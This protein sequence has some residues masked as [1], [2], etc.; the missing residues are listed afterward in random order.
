[1]TLEGTFDPVE[2]SAEPLVVHRSGTGPPVV[3]VHGGMPAPMTW[4]AQQELTADWSL[5]VPNRRGFPPS[6]TAPWQDFLADTDDLADLLEQIPGGAHLAG[7]SYGGLGAVL[8][9][10]RLPHL[11][12]SLT[13]IE[14]PLWIAAEDDDAVRELAELSDRFA[15]SVDD[16]EAEAEFFAVAGVDP[17]MFAELDEDVRQALELGRKLRSP[18]EAKPRFETITEAG[19]PVL[20]ASGEHSPALERVC[21][22]V[23][24]RLAARRVHLPGAGHAVQHAPGFNTIFDEFLTSAEQQRRSTT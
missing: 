11:I 16:A 19:V 1:M 24:E 2:S 18:R 20:V 6:P 7:F 10:E 17:K 3:L 13:V 23:A 14:A 9:A 4:A 22:G 12:R 8:V 15:A 5:I 21:D